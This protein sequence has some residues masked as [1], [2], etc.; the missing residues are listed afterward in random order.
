MYCRPVLDQ[1]DFAVLA[2]HQQHLEELAVT[3][4]KVPIMAIDQ[5]IAGNCKRA[6]RTCASLVYSTLQHFPGSSGFR[7]RALRSEIDDLSE[8]C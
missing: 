4:K 7:A 3:C 6:E 1:G 5:R 8:S 2:C